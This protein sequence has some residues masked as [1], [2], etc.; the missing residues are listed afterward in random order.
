MR[1][2]AG[3]AAI[4]R[5]WVWRFVEEGQAHVAMA[6]EVLEQLDLAQGALG[7][8]LLAED[9]GDLLDGD[10]LVGLV[11]DSGTVPASLVSNGRRIP[12]PRTRSARAWRG[13]GQADKTG[14]VRGA[15]YQTMPYAPWP[16]SLVT[17]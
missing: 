14:G 4:A 7:Q 5:D 13:R 3:A 1:N 11:I 12:A 10:T 17:V 8:D 9:I 16:N 6:S 2:H 15:T